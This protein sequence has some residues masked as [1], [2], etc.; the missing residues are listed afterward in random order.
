MTKFDFGDLVLAILAAWCAGAVTFYLHPSIAA[1]GAGIITVLL[2]VYY[3]GI[4]KVG[5]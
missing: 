5:G 4:E 2:L 1:A 3:V